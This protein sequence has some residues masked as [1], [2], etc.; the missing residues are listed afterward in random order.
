[1]TERTA[2]PQSALRVF[3]WPLVIGLAA[4]CGLILGLTGD[5]LPDIAA[6][7]LV[8]LVPATAIVGALRRSRRTSA[9][10]TQKAIP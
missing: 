5:G 8:G 6:W 9:R 10:T 7:L 2:H 4:L 3:A 1:M